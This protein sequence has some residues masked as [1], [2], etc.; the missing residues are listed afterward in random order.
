MDYVKM[1]TC[2][3][4]ECA[5]DAIKAHGDTDKCADWFRKWEPDYLQRYRIT[6][7]QYSLSCLM[8]EHAAG[9]LEQKEEIKKLSAPSIRLQHWEQIRRTRDAE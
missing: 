5:L 8:M 4:L 3:K 1:D 9:L 2:T 6:T 7:M